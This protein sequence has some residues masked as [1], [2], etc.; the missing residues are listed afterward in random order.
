[1]QTKDHSARPTRYSGRRTQVSE[2]ARNA[3]LL[4]LPAM[5]RGNGRPATPWPPIDTATPD[6]GSFPRQLHHERLSK[7]C[8][9]QADGTLLARERLGVARPGVPGGDE[10]AS[11]LETDGRETG[12]PLEGGE[13]PHKTVAQV[14]RQRLIVC[15]AEVRSHRGRSGAG[16]VEQ[17]K[18]R[19]PAAVRGQHHSKEADQRHERPVSRFPQVHAGILA[20]PVHDPRVDRNS[21]HARL[22]SRLMRSRIRGGAIPRRGEAIGDGVNC[23]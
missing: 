14:T 16:R 6:G 18:R 2:N 12:H 3:V 4:A 5:S 1:M 7:R 22:L 11:A 13:M 21:L 9:G 8:P 17:E 20:G 10:V 23:Q 19:M 15:D